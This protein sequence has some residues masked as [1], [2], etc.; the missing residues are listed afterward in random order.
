GPSRAGAAAVPGLAGAPDE[1]VIAFLNLLSGTPEEALRDPE[2]GPTLLALVRRDLALL[3][4][5]QPTGA[6]PLPCPVSVY[7]GRADPV[8]PVEELDGWR[9]VA[10]EGRGRLFARGRVLLVEQL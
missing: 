5:Y 7:G 2:V 1:D 9:G 8:V 6:G 4:A 10:A 3:E